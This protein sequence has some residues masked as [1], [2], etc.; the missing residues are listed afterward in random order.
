M[1]TTLLAV[2]LFAF[3]TTAAFSQAH[4]PTP[5]NGLVAVAEKP[6]PAGENEWHLVTQ[7]AGA[8]R[9]ISIKPVI[10]VADGAPGTKANAYAVNN[11]FK[12]NYRALKRGQDHDLTMK[13]GTKTGLAK[14]NAENSTYTIY[15]NEQ[16]VLGSVVYGKHGRYQVWSDENVMLKDSGNRVEKVLSYV[17]LIGI[18]IGVT[19]VATGA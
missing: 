8:G 15:D 5:E 13:N 10:T 19:A 3:Y 17:V 9:T 16:N 18:G 4:S 6:R 2:I 1:K 14:W 7:A 12:V 11:L